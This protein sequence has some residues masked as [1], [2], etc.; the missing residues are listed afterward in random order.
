MDATSVGDTKTTKL[1]T[2]CSVF[3]EEKK[4]NKSDLELL[5]EKLAAMLIEEKSLLQL[6]DKSLWHNLSREIASLQA[7]LKY[8]EANANKSPKKVISE[9]ED[10][11]KAS[12]A[13]TVPA[14][15][16][17]WQNTP[18]ELST[19]IKAKIIAFVASLS[20][21]TEPESLREQIEYAVSRKFAGTSVT[22]AMNIAFKLITDGR[23]NRPQGYQ[24]KA[25][26][27]YNKHV[28]TYSEQKVKE[29]SRPRES[30][31]VHAAAY[32]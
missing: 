1:P 8:L 28:D 15:N 25:L 23:W 3:F 30:D 6:S 21:C 14:K 17:Y 4:A 26:Y 20:H 11:P 31:T 9:Q 7:H 29:C 24:D 32:C 5:K 13:P 18:V 16:K 19:S 12:I 27:E 22:H 10:A 2:A